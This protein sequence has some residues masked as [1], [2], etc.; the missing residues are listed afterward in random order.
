MLPETRKLISAQHSTV[1]YSQRRNR[2]LLCAAEFLSAYGPVRFPTDNFRSIPSRCI[3][4]G[5]YHHTFLCFTGTVSVCALDTMLVVTMWAAVF[6]RGIFGST[7]ALPLLASNNF[8]LSQNTYTYPRNVSILRRSL[9]TK[10]TVYTPFMRAFLVGAI[11]IFRFDIR[12]AF[13][14]LEISQCNY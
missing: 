3:D 6:H 14:L 7:L 4:Q 11:F 1:L 5:I 13:T 12:I 9:V 10:A 2:F 8:T